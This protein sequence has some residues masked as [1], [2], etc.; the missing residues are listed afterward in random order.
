MDIE[1]NF[2]RYPGEDQ[3]VV[4][5]FKDRLIEQLNQRRDAY[6]YNLNENAF[7]TWL[8]FYSDYNRGFDTSYLNN[9]YIDNYTTERA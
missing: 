7:K 5:K 3:K 4:E 6:L 8:Y 1:E 9:K 2:Y